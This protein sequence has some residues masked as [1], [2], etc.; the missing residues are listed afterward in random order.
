VADA[1]AQYIATIREVILE[2]DPH[3]KI[4]MGFFAPQFPNETGIGDMRFVDTA[5]LVERDV[6]LDFWD[7]HAYPGDGLTFAQFMQNFGLEGYV[8]KP[9]V[10]GEFGGFKSRFD[11]MAAAARASGA[12]MAGFCEQGVDGYLYW[13]L[14]DLPAELGDHTW[15]LLKADAFMLNLFAP[16][17]QPDPCTPPEVPSDNLAYGAAV[18]ASREL[19]EDASTLAVDENTTTTWGAGAG[20][21][22]WIE[23]DL[24]EEQTIN[25]IHLLT[26][27]WPAGE[28][29]H[30]I[31]VRGESTAYESVQ[32][33]ESATE[34]FQ[35]LAFTPELPLEN[36]RYIRIHTLSS[37][38][39]VGWREIEVK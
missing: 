28:T 10:L 25:T 6:P 27:Q 1:L 38:S 7:I 37:P 11:T 21:P 8:Q 23:I 16:E 15:G 2:S 33:F 13:S 20:A 29:I 17:N 18:T 22:Q 39:W 19:A 31:R 12:W 4:T 36:V 26:S 32:R 3:A 9:V 5:A 30:E 14:T 34:D 35:W 24:G